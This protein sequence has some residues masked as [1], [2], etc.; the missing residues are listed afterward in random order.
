MPRGNPTKRELD[1][2]NTFAKTALEGITQMAS[3]L[4]ALPLSQTP[5]SLHD[6]GADDGFLPPVNQ[7]DLFQAHAVFFITDGHMGVGAHSGTIFDENG[8]EVAAPTLVWLNILVVHPSNWAGEWSM[9]VGERAYQKAAIMNYLE[10]PDRHGPI[11]PL[12][13]QEVTAKSGFDFFKFV[14]AKLPEDLPF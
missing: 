10:K 4:P 5:V 2:A 9:C 14:P 3:N 1:Q 7:T 11:G 8:N 6:I 13:L 12:A